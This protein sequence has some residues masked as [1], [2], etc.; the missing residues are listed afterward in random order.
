MDDLEKLAA[1][2]HDNKMKAERA[3]ARIRNEQA[4]IQ[5]SPDD[6]V[7]FMLNTSKTIKAYKNRHLR[8]TD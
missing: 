2:E 4:K 8:T 5:M 7:S 6:M 3:A 1:I